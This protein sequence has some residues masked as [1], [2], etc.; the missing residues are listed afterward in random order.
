MLNFSRVF[1]SH[2]S[3]CWW[4]CFDLGVCGLEAW[5]R[6]HPHWK[7][8]HFSN[9]AICRPQ[10]VDLYFPYP[11]WALWNLQFA[12]PLQYPARNTLLKLLPE[13]SRNIPKYPESIR[14]QPE[15]WGGENERKE[16]QRRGKWNVAP[17]V[18]LC[19]L[20][21]SSWHITW[22]SRWQ[23]FDLIL[24]SKRGSYEKG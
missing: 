7:S 14:K 1:P 19:S 21:Q 24:S 3:C 12:S 23:C 13:I 10:G 5:F 6:P 22:S 11:L 8:S 15:E 2:A 17:S 18:K 4:G 20:G 16:M 9:L